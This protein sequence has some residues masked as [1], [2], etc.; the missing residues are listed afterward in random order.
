MILEFLPATET[1]HFQII[2]NLSR[3]I[4]LEISGEYIPELPHIYFFID[5][6]L[7]VKSLNVHSHRGNMNII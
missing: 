4:L 2:E 5:K 6:S 7:T 1:S 3:I